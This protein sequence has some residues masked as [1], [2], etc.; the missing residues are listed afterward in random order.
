LASDFLPKTNENIK[1]LLKVFD[2]IKVCQATAPINKFDDI[3]SSVSPQMSESYGM[4][5]HLKCSSILKSDN[6]TDRLL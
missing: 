3:N 4:W 2:E 5:R 6:S 1:Y